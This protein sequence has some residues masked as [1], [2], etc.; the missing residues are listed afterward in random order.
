[1]FGGPA[2]EPTS[3]RI[4][5][6]AREAG[7]NFIDTADVYN[8]GGSEE[9]VDR[10]ICGERDR[11]VIATKVNGIMGGGPNQRGS[12]R[13]WILE[14]ARRSLARLGTDYRHLLPPL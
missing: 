7:I 8:G 9:V 4:V 3:Q 1:M 14:A 11:W 5:G 12:S 2:D 6:K 13:K 10:A